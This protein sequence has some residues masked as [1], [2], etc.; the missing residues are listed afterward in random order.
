MRVLVMEDIGLMAVD[1]R[2]APEPGPG[3]ALVAVTATGICGSDL[4]GYT[5]ENGRRVPGQVMGHETVGHVVRYHAEP[6]PG[7]PPPGTPVTVNPLMA[8]GT[9]AQCS[10]GTLHLC[11]HRRVIGVDPSFSAA[12]ADLMVVPAVNLVPWNPVA[13]LMHGA[14][15][16]PLAVGMHAAS[17]G[18]V[19]EGDVVLVIGA[20]PIGQAAVI[21]AQ[22]LG[23]ASVLVSE[24]MASRRDIARELGAQ[25]YDP[26]EDDVVTATRDHTGGVGAPVVIDAV[27]SSRTLAS[28]IDATARGGRCVLVGMGAPRIDIAA[29]GLSTEE[30]ALIGAFCYTHDEFAGTAEWAGRHAGVLSPLISRSVDLL[31][32]PEQFRNLASGQDD[33][34]KIIIT[35]AG[36]PDPP[37]GSSD[38]PERETGA[39]HR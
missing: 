7:A 14:L 38:V 1:H 2:P 10:A 5:G 16:E 4:H 24:P 23:A 29:F 17:R 33:A 37:R 15:V 28:G 6:P 3:Q 20:G 12:F 8:C 13:P 11:A 26:T 35:F 32:A 19:T 21:A 22:R 34:S 25:P 30:R 31:Q 39:P 36:T 9:C 27:G 18:G